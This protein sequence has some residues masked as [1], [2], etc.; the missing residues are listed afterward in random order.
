MAD[1]FKR[2]FGSTI[3]FGTHEDRRSSEFLDCGRTHFFDRMTLWFRETTPMRRSGNVLT[4]S[5]HFWR[6][7][8]AHPI[9]VD[10]EVVRALAGNPGCLDLY[11]WLTWRCFKAKGQ[12]RIPL[13]GPFGLSNQ[14][15]VQ[16]YARQRKFRERV[17]TWLRLVRLYW[18]ECPAVLA[19]NGAFIEIRN[20][21]AIAEKPAP[22]L[23]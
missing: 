1:G 17:A 20:S 3:F 10:C 22:A 12:E 14:L 16:E 11:T 7:L 15:G 5:E 9:P 23:A 21:V 2:V 19:R 8:K 18:P 6:E 4:L 13:F